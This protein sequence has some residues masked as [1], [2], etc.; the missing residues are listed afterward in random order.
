[1]A[2]EEIERDRIS[3]E[4]ADLTAMFEDAATLAVNGQTDRRSLDLILADIQQ[5]WS[6]LAA[7]MTVL[8]SIERRIDGVESGQ[9]R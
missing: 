7:S 4:F 9:V 2:M 6:I 1:M 8:A 3:K 5:L